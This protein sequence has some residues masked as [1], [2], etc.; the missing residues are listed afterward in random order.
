MTTARDLMTSNPKCVAE[1]ENLVS[2]ARQMRDLDVGSMPICGD[3]KN[4]KGMLTDRDIVVKWSQG[5]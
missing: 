3:D 2:A 4:L 5:R 1:D